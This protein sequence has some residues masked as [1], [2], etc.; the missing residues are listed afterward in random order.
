MPEFDGPAHVGEGWQEK[1]VTACFNMEPWVDYCSEPPCGQFDPTKSNLYD[2]LENIYREM[3]NAF[4]RPDRFH[5]GGDEVTEECWKT[6]QN[7][8]D[9]IKNRDL[10][11]TTN[12]FM[13]LW[14]YFQTNAVERIDR[15]ANEN[16]KIIL[17]TSTLTGKNYVEK[18]LDK[19]KYVIQVR[20]IKIF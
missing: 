16:T 14:G 6:S 9:W 12:A 13:E 19:E 7:I 11:V 15:I 5:M 4:G 2:I 20:K 3:Y 10:N 18:Y 17:W 1:N 8:L